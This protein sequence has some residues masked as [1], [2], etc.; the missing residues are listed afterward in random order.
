MN[1]LEQLGLQEDRLAWQD[2]A[3]CRR[4]DPKYFDK[5]YQD[6]PVVRPMVD[7]ICINCPVIKECFTSAARNKESFLWAATWL[8]NGQ[9]VSEMSDHQ[10]KEFKQRLRERLING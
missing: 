7:E 5:Y 8:D 9:P 1:I 3:A 6:N 2:L 4:D 10:T